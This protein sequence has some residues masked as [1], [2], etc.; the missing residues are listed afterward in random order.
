MTLRR[1]GL[2][3]DRLVEA[4]T[5]VSH[6][7]RALLDGSRD[8]RAVPGLVKRVI[9]EEMW[10]QWADP[11][12]GRAWGPFRSFEHFVITPAEHGGLGSTIAQLRGL[13][14]NDVE[15]RNDIERA[16]KGGQLHGGDRRSETFKLDNIQLESYPSGTS[17]S[18]ALRRL[19][20]DRPDLHAEVLA[21]RL[22]AHAAMVEAGFRQKTIS[23]PVANPETV[24]R[25]LLKYM[26]P[27]DVA[28]LVALLLGKEV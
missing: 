9:R 11:S 19:R 13:C 2:V 10:R 27:D 20:N 12:S 7:S 28:K 22:S 23:V 17:E 8:L 6:L 24:A 26:K 21:E 18:A 3:S 25:A 16:V 15:A 4:G 5:I 1:N 14:E